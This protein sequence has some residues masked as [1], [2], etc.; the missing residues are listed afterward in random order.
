MRLLLIE[1]SERLRRSLARGLRKE[2]YA[3]DVAADGRE[4]LWY[5]SENVYDVIILDLMLPGIDGLTL[6]RTLRERGNSTYVLILSARDMVEDRVQGLSLGADDYL[7]K[8][9]SF[10]ELCARLNALVRRSYGSKTPELCVGNLTVDTRSHQVLQGGQALPFTLREYG[11][12]ELLARRSGKVV[13]RQE[14]WDHLY[15]LDSET[16]SNV[17]EVMICSLR[18]KLGPDADLIKTRRGQGYVLAQGEA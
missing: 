8:P 6:L 2:A 13:S 11:L 9:F 12:I 16:A 15:E 1:D 17:I 4:G 14:L 10:P 18:R 7:V 5:A 3:V